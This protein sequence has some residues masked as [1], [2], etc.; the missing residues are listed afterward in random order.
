MVATTKTVRRTRRTSDAAADRKPVSVTI[1]PT[2]RSLIDLMRDH[3]NVSYEEV[4]RRIFKSVETAEIKRKEL[5]DFYR[6][7]WQVSVPLRA[8]ER[9]NVTRYNWS[10]AMIATLETVST[11]V[12]PRQNQSEAFRLVVTYYALKNKYAKIEWTRAA[13]FAPR[14]LQTN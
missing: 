12:L 1:D 13:K 14:T 11:E 2:T 4:I 10:P 5:R 7:T 3:M 9:A 6:D 8:G